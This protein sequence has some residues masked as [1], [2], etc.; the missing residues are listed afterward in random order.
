MKCDRLYQLLTT[1]WGED[2]QACADIAEHI[3][4]CPNCQRG[5]TRLAG[6]LVTEDGLSCE[7]C[8]SL[9]PD[10]YEA[11]RPDYSLVHMPDRSVAQV[12]FHLGYCAACREE[13][14]ELTLLWHLEERERVE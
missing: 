7:E 1:N 8:R 9:L 14:Q 11:T 3:R 10:Y 2:Q 13:Y 5:L 12:A 6:E 4:T